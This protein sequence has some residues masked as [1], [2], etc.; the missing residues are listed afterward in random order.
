MP[1]F[2]PRSHPS[3]HVAL[4]TSFMMLTLQ[5]SSAQWSGLVW[6]FL[7]VKLTLCTFGKSAAQVTL[8]LP[9]PP[10]GVCAFSGAQCVS[11]SMTPW[12]VA[13][14]GPLSMGFSQ[15]KHWSGLPFPSP[16]GLPDPGWACIS[17]IFG[18][19]RWIRHHL[20]R[21]RWTLHCTAWEAQ[22]EDDVNVSLQL[23][24]LTLVS[25]VRWCLRGS[26]VIKLLFFIINKNHD[27]IWNYVNTPF[28]IRF[29]PA[30]PAA[31]DNSYPES[32][33]VLRRSMPSR[34]HHPFSLYSLEF[35]CEGELSLLPHVS[36]LFI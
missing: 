24:L 23:V 10:G 13:H 4:S 5:E 15:Q 36:S 33:S 29:S 16:G 27:D 30:N 26:S 32:H 31:I 14:Q 12:T 21:E 17:C 2:W 8:C 22:E 3:F 34:F 25:P 20:H 35:H 11:D 7:V 19:G 18:I 28:F 9:Q 6:C 1:F